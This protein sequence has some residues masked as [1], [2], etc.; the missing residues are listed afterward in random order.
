ML[1]SNLPPCPVCHREATS[2]DSE[3]IRG[4]LINC[5]RCSE[6]MITSTVFTRVASLDIDLRLI[7]SYYLANHKET[8]LDTTSVNKILQLTTLPDFA[9]IQNTFIIDRKSTR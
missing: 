3:P 6:Y 5:R 1:T 7:L 4:Y 8:T 2:E 9:D